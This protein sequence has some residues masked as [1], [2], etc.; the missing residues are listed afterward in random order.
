MRIIAKVSKVILKC[1]C[2]NEEKEAK[3]FY[4]SQ[5]P[6]FRATRKLPICKSCMLDIYEENLN[7]Y[8]N[9]EK[10]LYKTLFSL[11]ICYDMKLA[12]RALIDT[13]NTDKHILKAYMSSINLKNYKDKTAKD[14]PPFNIWD[15]PEEKF[16]TYELEDIQPPEP[17]LISKEIIQ[18]WGGGRSNE[19]YM[20]LQ[21]EYENMCATYGNKNPYSLSSYEQIALYRLQLRK[22]WMKDNPNSKVINDINASISKIA[23]DCKMKELQI[24]SSEDDTLRFSKFIEMIEYKEP[25]PKSEEYDDIDGIRKVIKEDYIRPLA[26]ALDLEM[27]DDRITRKKKGDNNGSNEES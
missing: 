26:Q 25:I 27:V 8:K 3:E 22:E 4:T 14:S 11:D 23:G 10:A 12:K 9:E 21:D 6:M 17:I 2:C 18:R 7:F 19:D 1:N 5:S 16:N 20:F 15:I 24:D 13:Y